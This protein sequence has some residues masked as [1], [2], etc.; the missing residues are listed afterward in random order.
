MA[1]NNVPLSGQ[2]LNTTRAPINQ[3]FSL[4]NTAFVVDHV[5]Y[6][7]SGQGKH[8]KVTFPVQGSAPT[9]S[10]GEIGLYNLAYNN[11]TNTVNELFVHK[12]E[13]VSSTI[14]IPFTSS[15]LSSSAVSANDNGW[16]YLPSGL[17]IKWG[18][19]AATTSTVTVNFQS[20]SGGPA[21]RR[22]FRSF[23]T[24]ADTSSATNFN[25]GIRSVGS[26]TS[27]TAYCNNPSGTTSLRYLVIGA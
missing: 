6:Q 27:F 21:Y 25:C 8:N 13:N 5:E 15:S 1:L 10:T 19:L 11:G 12:L 3:N 7:T 9:F 17:L 4:I 22:V 20:L 26:T 2:D 14:D 23:I 16:S 24:P 18:G